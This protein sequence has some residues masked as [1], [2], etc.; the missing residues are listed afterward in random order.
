MCSNPFWPS[1]TPNIH[2]IQLPNTIR[3]L[4]VPVS[5]VPIPYRSPS[6]TCWVLCFRSGC[7]CGD[8]TIFTLSP[9]GA[10]ARRAGLAQSSMWTTPSIRLWAPAFNHS[11]KACSISVCLLSVSLFRLC[12]CPSVCVAINVSTYP[13]IRLSISFLPVLFDAASPS[14]CVVIRTYRD[15]KVSTYTDILW[16]KENNIH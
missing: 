1:D 6:S 8:A 15:N 12:V 5:C 7:Q 13:S 9:G 4:C 16:I 2:P 14:F 11:F 3:L 10:W